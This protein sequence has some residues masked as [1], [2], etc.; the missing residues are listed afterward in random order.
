MDTNN[1]TENLAESEKA[2]VKRWLERIIAA[3]EK[4]ADDFKRMREDMEFAAGFQWPGQMKLCDDRYTANG[5]VYH[6]NS[7]VSSLYARD[8]RVEARRRRRRDFAMW[9]GK[10]ETMELAKTI[11]MGGPGAFP[12]EVFLPAQALMTDYAN[13]RMQ[14]DMVERVGETLEILYQWNT[15]NQQPTFKLQLKQLVR[16]VVTCGVG[17]TRQSFSRPEKQLPPS[18]SDI[19]NSVEDRIR[20]IHVISARM[21]EGE[22]FKD[23][24]A[25]VETLQSLAAGISDSIQQGDL[26]E[27]NE[28]LVFDFPPSTTIIPDTNCRALKGFIGARWVAQEYVLPLDEAN[29][30]F[31]VLIGQDDLSGEVRYYT[32]KG[33]PSLE[34]DKAPEGEAPKKYV[35]FFEVFNK[36]DRCRFILCDGYKGYVLPPESVWPQTKHFWPLHALTFNDI[37]VEPSQR[38]T[39]YPPS[40]VQLL[41]SIQEERNRSRHALRDHRKANA[42]KYVYPDGALDE[43]DL[44][45]LRDAVP[46]QA[47]GLKGVPP[48]TKVD[49]V[50]GSPTM[51]PL[52]PLLYETVSLQD[53]T[54][55]TVGTQEGPLPASTRG[56]ATAA[57][58][59]EQARNIATSSNVDDLDDHL[60]ILAEAGGEMLLRECSKETVQ[61]V[62]GPGAVWPEQN[63]AEFTD[64]IYLNVQ[65]ASSGR[66]NKALDLSNWQ[67]AAPILQGAGVDPVF[68][69]KE[70]LKR[71]DDYLDIDDA[72]PNGRPMPQ[73]QGP[74]QESK[75]NGDG[76][77]KQPGQGGKSQ[78]QGNQMPH[79]TQQ[80]K[81]PQ[82][83]TA[84]TQ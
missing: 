65:A 58:L 9:D 36:K 49:D 37:E 57:T 27:V 43:E 69:A 66:P 15:D 62:V 23:N 41:R 52:D 31:G 59:N 11:V 46:H 68:L 51:A 35:C 77:A 13:G 30:E 50:I 34:A 56:T 33:L 83:T 4:W 80:R 17:Y 20:R 28:R 25:D 10:L 54:R 1:P 71:L 5:L 75:Q 61:R 67:I 2:Q 60:S 70:T 6:I 45:K 79:S 3:R 7:K 42:P 21:L 81:M 14:K 48:G 73:P 26:E 44:K 32:E 64:E 78:Q 55:V 63:R 38:S 47:I 29:E 19:G 40:D 24:D 84:T 18:T 12:P 72:F 74:T 53:D 76:G 82:T 8:P 16:R 22:A 39:I